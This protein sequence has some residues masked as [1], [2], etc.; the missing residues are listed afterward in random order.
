MVLLKALYR[1][2]L[3]LIVGH[4]LTSKTQDLPLACRVLF[5]VNTFPRWRYIQ[6]YH[7]ES[8]I[9]TTGLSKSSSRC[10]I[11]RTI[12]KDTTTLYNL[13]KKSTILYQTHDLPSLPTQPRNPSSHLFQILDRAEQNIPS[14]VSVSISERNLQITMHLINLLG[15]G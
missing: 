3:E 4:D 8:W 14:R 5:P 7:T 13:R 15:M 1:Y 9:E 2:G 10:S 12:P 6:R 11:C